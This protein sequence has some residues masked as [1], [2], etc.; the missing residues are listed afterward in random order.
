[1]NQDVDR[2]L[3]GNYKTGN[4]MNSIGDSNTINNMSELTIYLH[5]RVLIL[6][7]SLYLYD[8]SRFCYNF[9]IAQLDD[10]SSETVLLDSELAYNLSL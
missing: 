6:S 9:D 1:M 4:N 8:Y 5:S 2:K 7:R 3:V 10:R